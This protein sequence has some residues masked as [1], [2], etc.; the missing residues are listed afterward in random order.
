MASFSIVLGAL[1]EEVF[2]IQKYF[3]WKK[4]IEWNGY[5]LFEGKLFGV[6]AVL[7]RTGIGKVHAALLTQR[8]IDVYNPKA[9]IFTGLAGALDKN[10]NI[11]DIVVAREL[12]QHDFSTE[13]HRHGHVIPKV[14]RKGAF[15]IFYSDKELVKKAMRCKPR[16]EHKTV[17]GRVLTGDQFIAR[18]ETNEDWHFL[19]E[20]KGDA[21]EMEGA[22]VA[23]VATVNK[24]PFVVVRTISDKADG[25]AEE[26]FQLSLARASENSVDVVQCIL[27]S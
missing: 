21:V 11:G 18:F 15:P 24:V 22:A 23:H 1:P 26:D 2:E 17:A 10:L 13:V 25:N 8:L 6:P 20:L 5:T 14:D 12:I 19:E 16:S 3:S 7:A 9:I 4:E 27:E